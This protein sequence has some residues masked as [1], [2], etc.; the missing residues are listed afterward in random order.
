MSSSS[1]SDDDIGEEEEYTTWEETERMEAKFEENM[2]ESA[3]DDALFSSM[4]LTSSYKV[5]FCLQL[6]VGVALWY[7]GATQSSV[8]YILR[9]RGEASNTSPICRTR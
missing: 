3:A 8:P 2:L 1:S 5:W 6:F 7:S 4:A 9:N